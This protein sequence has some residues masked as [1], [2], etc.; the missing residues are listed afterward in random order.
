MKGRIL[1]TGAS[2]FI[3]RHTL[4][5]LLACGYEVHAVT[6]SKNLSDVFPAVRW[7]RADLLEPAVIEPLLAKVRPS[8]LL[9]LAWDVTPGRYWKAP[10]NLDWVA[11]SLH[12]LREFAKQGGQR[13]VY[14]GTCAEYDWS[15]AVLSEDLTALNPRTPYGNAKK[16][17]QTLVEKFSPILNLSSAWGR[18]FFLYGPHEAPGRLVPQVISS[19]LRNEEARCTQGL[20]ERDFLYVQDVADAFVRLVECEISGAVN[21]SSGQSIAVRSVIDAIAKQVP[22]QGKI[23]LGAVPLAADEPDR[24]VGDTS[25]LDQLGFKPRY[26]LEQGIAESIAWWKSELKPQ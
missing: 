14:A 4:P 20:H 12:L 21:I 10:E 2:G 6:R 23:S 11:A 25:R 18:I 16:A 19:L 9:H 7:H 13:A 26:S 17:L 8:H 3:G 5:G 24:L 1:V 15:Q 22:S